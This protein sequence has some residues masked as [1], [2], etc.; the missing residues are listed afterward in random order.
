MKVIL[1]QLQIEP[2]A[3][4]IPVRCSTNWAMKPRRK[5]VRCEFNW[6]PLY[7]E[8]EMCVWLRSKSYVCT[9][10]REYQWKWSSQLWSNKGNNIF[11][12]N[13]KYYLRQEKEWQNKAHVL[14][15]GLFLRF[16]RYW[17][18]ISK[19]SAFSSFEWHDTCKDKQKQRLYTL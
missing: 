2:M 4:V 6:Y 12:Q 5:Q 1:K 3:S 10:E 11:S 19:I 9:A 16:F 8:S 7:E 13:G 17:T 15:I 18:V 14:V